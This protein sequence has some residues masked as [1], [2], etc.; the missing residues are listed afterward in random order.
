MS[1]VSEMTSGDLM[2]LAKKI[3][4]TDAASYE[5]AALALAVIAKQ[6]EQEGVNEADDERPDTEAYLEI[7]PTGTLVAYWSN[8]GLKSAAI[9]SRNSSQ[10]LV[11]LE[12]KYG[13]RMIVDYGDIEW[14]KAGKW[15]P[16][17]I[18]NMLVNG[19]RREEK[20]EPRK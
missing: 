18:Y 6:Q 13:Y 2:A 10:R 7:A 20:N 8:K 4:I 16:K 1:N 11:K 15:W 9:V 3:G 19:I 12:T 17:E 14:V 5:K